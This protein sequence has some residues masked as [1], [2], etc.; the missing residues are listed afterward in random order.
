MTNHEDFC[1][2]L[3]TTLIPDLRESGFG[4]TADDFERAVELIEDPPRYAL[5]RG[6]AAMTE[7]VAA[8]LPGNY[9]VVGRT[10][11]RASDE[12]QIL[13]AGRDVAG[14][15]L[16]DYVIPRLASGLIFAEEIA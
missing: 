3:T 7:R 2:Y 11:I 5:V 10:A 1:R 15:T 8:Y 13:I 4:A 12:V 14:W 9:R 6:K 16:D